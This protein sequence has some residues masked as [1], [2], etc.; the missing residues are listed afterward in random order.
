METAL[1]S[2]SQPITIYAVLRQITWGSTDT[3]WE[4]SIVDAQYNRITQNGSTPDLKF[5]SG[6]ISAAN[7]NLAVGSKGMITTIGNGA[8]GF[9]QVNNTTALTG[10]YGSLGVQAIQLATDTNHAARFGN[11]QL[12][13]FLMFNA[14]HNASQRALVQNY[15]AARHG[16]VL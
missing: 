8:N 12:Y 4:C 3:L 5:T 10:N 13:E 11:F 16:L 7:A 14:A 1:F 2:L 15:L 6:T 9:F